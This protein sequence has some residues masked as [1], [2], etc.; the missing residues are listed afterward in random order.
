MD[1][2]L[3]SKRDI[4]RRNRTYHSPA[5]ETGALPICYPDLIGSFKPK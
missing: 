1:I 3:L 4:R 2:H 5:Y